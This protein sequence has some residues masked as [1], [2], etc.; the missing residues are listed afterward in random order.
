[1]KRNRIR[2]FT[3][4]WAVAAAAMLLALVFAGIAGAYPTKGIDGAAPVTLTVTANNP[5]D[6]KAISGLK[7]TV[8]KAA[9]MEV[10]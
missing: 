3:R 8:F 1:M 5:S 4:K 7:L 10:A 6:G 9:D 2:N